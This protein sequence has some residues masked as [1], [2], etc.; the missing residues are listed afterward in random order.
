MKAY[1]F[2]KKAG[3]LTSK[4]QHR[5]HDFARRQGVNYNILAVLYTCYIN[6]GCSQKQVTV[7]W[8][9]PKQTVNTVCKELIAEGLLSKVKSEKDRRESIIRLTQEGIKRAAPIVERL[10]KIESDIVSSMGEEGASH[11]LEIY[12]SYSEILSAAF[13]KE[14]N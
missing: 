12:S 4:N 8:Y 2:M 5:Y 9:V 6:G 13:K 3:E 7:E 10:L 14:E 11:F 1:E